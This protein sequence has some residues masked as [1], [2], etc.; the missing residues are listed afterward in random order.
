MTAPTR[1]ELLMAAA[2]HERGEACFVAAASAMEQTIETAHT[3]HYLDRARALLG[4]EWQPIETAPKQPGHI[5]VRF[6]VTYRWLPYKPQSHQCRAGIK[7]R[8]QRAVSN[9]YGGWENAC[10]PQNGEWRPPQPLPL[11]PVQE[12]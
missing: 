7:G 1:A 5:D 6:V 12:K 11:P 2:L 10:L 9:E 3:R 4:S 8:W